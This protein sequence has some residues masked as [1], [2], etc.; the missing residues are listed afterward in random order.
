MTV[1]NCI[2][3]IAKADIFGMMK[4]NLS[5]SKKAQLLPLQLIINVL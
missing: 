2:K 5:N 1:I 4:S 3:N